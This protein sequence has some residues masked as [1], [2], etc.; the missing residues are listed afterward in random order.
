[1]RVITHQRQGKDLKRV[2]HRFTTT[3]LFVSAAIL[4]FILALVDGPAIWRDANAG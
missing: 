3:L 1:M 2:M 4:V